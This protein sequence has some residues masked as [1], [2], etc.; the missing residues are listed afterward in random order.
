MSSE[1]K[2]DEKKQHFDDIY[3]ADTPVPYKVQILDAL[4]YISDNFNREMFETHFAL[5]KRSIALS[6][7]C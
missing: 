2:T 5:G 1:I 3:V 7:L 6:E 4:T